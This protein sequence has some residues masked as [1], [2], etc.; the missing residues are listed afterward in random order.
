MQGCP[1]PP[2]PWRCALQS[3]L[4]VKTRSAVI[5]AVLS[6]PSL[7]YSSAAARGQVK[8]RLYFNPTIIINDGYVVEMLLNVSLHEGVFMH[9]KRALQR[10]IWASSDW[11]GIRGDGTMVALCSA[12]DSAAVRVHRH[13]QSQVQNTPFHHP[14]LS[15]IDISVKWRMKRKGVDR[16]L[17]GKAEEKHAD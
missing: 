7:Q 10:N 12:C 16:F 2:Y 1:P 5:I 14:P 4:V 6:K 13:A 11:T 17:W 3:S 9:C 15:N 8:A